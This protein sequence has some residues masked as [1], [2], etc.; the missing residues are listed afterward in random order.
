LKCKNLE[1]VTDMYGN[2]PLVYA[3]KIKDRDV[4]NLFVEFYIS[5]PNQ[6]NNLSFL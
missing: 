3:F 1:F 2:N 6:I 4:L 5:N